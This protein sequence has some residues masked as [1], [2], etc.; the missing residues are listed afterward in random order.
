M[1][2][3]PVRRNDMMANVQ[4]LRDDVTELTR[5]AINQV[6]AELS[7]SLTDL[8]DRAVNDIT[9]MG[10]TLA[11]YQESL[12][13]NVEE[14]TT[15]KFEQVNEGF[16]AESRRVHTLI[17]SQADATSELAD[18]TRQEVTEVKAQ[19]SSIDHG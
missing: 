13:S 9:S 11:R 3:D 14:A 19:I 12:S 1:A 17:Q 15:S 18:D 16:M 7:A 4:S 2:D 5:G 8:N 10:A 6:G